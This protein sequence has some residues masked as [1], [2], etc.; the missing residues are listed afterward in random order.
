MATILIV[1]DDA[2]V[3]LFYE[4]E[5]ASE[6]HLVDVLAQGRKLRERLDSGLPD[7]IVLDL[8]LG[9]C[10]GRVILQELHRCWPKLPV[11]VSSGYDMDPRELEKL[12]AAFVPKSHDLTPLKLT[13]KRVLG[14]G[15]PAR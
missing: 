7:V 2:A 8:N 13:I 6:G 15:G 9:D 4:E 1:E 14:D 3:G 10:D 12:G 5:L 11:I